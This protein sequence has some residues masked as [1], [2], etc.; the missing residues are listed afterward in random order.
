MKNI[1]HTES[2]G[3]VEVL[4]LIDGVE[5]GLADAMNHHVRLP[6]PTQNR[7][8]LDSADRNRE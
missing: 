8:R 1:G 7:D 3:D 5:A 4:W 6:W 2:R